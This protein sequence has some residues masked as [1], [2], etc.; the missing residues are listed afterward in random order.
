MKAL[1]L[2]APWV[3]LGYL[4]CYGS[5]W[6]R[7]P[8]LDRLAAEG[9][10][11]DQHYA[12]CPTPTAAFANAADIGPNR[13]WWTGRFAF[14]GAAPVQAPG[15][16]LGLLEAQGIATGRVVA[17]HRLATQPA[18]PSLDFPFEEIVDA[19]E[20]LAA[21]DRWLL[22]VD[23]PGLAPPWAV[24]DEI[25]SIYFA[26]EPGEDEEPLTP[27]PDPP[28][29]PLDRDDGL[30]RERLQTTYAAA[31]SFTDAQLGLLLDELR[32]RALYESLLIVFTSDRGLALGEHG[33]VGRTGLHEV[34]LHLPL[35]LR[36][37]GGA[38]AG[39]RVAGLT[40]PVD[41]FPTLLEAFGVA[42][43][44]A[45]GH[46]LLPLTRGTVEQGR[47]YA[48]AGLAV[49]A[50]VEY[51]LRTPEW[52]LHLPP[53]APGEAPPRP[54]LFVK[55]DD[56]WEV[57]DVLQHHLDRAEALE[58]TLRGFVAATQ[59]PGPFLPPELPDLDALP[60]AGNE[61]ETTATR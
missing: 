40:Q 13:S 60:A 14:P 53:Q 24:P 36:L 43:P 31:V 7:T 34:F 46:S 48:C 25:L 4:G 42:A 35:L 49:G 51:A 57:N 29:G 1:V 47:P 32:E 16:L 26:E 22:W 8:N 55:P 2:A 19:L 30:D 27:W 39:A 56:R 28:D 21:R 58:R 50:G 52:G 33:V 20:G 41:L 44:E 18:P 38:E 61:P 10:V 15:S 23:L 37:P 54:Q 59:P 11:F 45:H 6:V 3:H 12:D 5:D 17:P 9:V